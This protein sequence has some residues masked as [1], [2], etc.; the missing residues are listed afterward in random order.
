MEQ[1]ITDIVILKQVSKLT[2]QQEVE[3]LRLVER[4]KEAIKGAWT[5]GFGLASVQI[6]VLLRMCW[7]NLAPG[8]SQ[9]AAD[10][11][12][13][14]PLIVEKHGPFITQGEGCLSLPHCWVPTK[15]YHSIKVNNNGRM[16]VAEGLEAQVIQHE[17]DH[18]DGVLIH[19]RAYRTIKVGRNE[20]CPCGSGKKHKR[21]CYAKDFT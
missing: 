11:I 9:P 4:L 5:G 13:I 16:F 19:D 21:C 14:N 3:E 8:C 17:V 20:P 10:V 2:T 6:G 1:I 15:R 7:Y 12:L 18:M